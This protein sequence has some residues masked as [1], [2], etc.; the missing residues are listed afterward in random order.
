MSAHASGALVAE[1]E[2]SLREP[3]CGAYVGASGAVATSDGRPHAENPGSGGSS[4]F[5]PNVGQGSPFGVCRM[6]GDFRNDPLQQTDVACITICHTDTI[7][8][9]LPGR[10]RI[11]D[12]CPRSGKHM[13]D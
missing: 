1:R 9:V 6:G 3:A 13:L 10:Q 4:Q 2:Y 8:N 7:L 11:W 5:T 12:E